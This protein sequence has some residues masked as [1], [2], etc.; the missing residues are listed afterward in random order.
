[1]FQSR[2]PLMEGRPLLT[3]L[4]GIKSLQSTD[5]ADW[6]H[7]GVEFGYSFQKTGLVPR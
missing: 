5:E 6:S 4:A 1:M 2:E 3:L 7:I